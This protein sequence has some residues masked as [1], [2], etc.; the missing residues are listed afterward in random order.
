MTKVYKV[1]T[2]IEEID[3]DEHETIDMETRGVFEVFDTLDEALAYQ[4]SM[5]GGR[6]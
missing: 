1:W 6:Q 3:D 4:E 5:L 2:Y